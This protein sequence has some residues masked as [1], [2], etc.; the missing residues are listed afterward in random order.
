MIIHL[1]FIR[2]FLGTV[3]RSRATQPLATKEGRVEARMPHG[4]RRRLEFDR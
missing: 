4:P 3:E 1:Q 2:S